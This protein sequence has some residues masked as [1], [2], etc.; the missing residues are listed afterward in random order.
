M[1]LLVTRAHQDPQAT[2]QV[3]GRPVVP[4]Y[5]D[6]LRRF[7]DDMGLHDAVTFTGALS[8]ADLVAAM[9]G[10]DVLV[11]PSR[12]EGF[13][14]PALEAM[15]MGLPVVANRAGALPEVVG[16]AGVL[17]DATDPYELAGAVARVRGDQDLR[18]TLVAA[19]RQRLE[20]LDLA[21]AGDRGADQILALGG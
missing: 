8:D 13:G 1:G 20:A 15:S 14:V 6:A 10:A 7:V 3:V 16:D 18:K 11:L 5:S 17:V 4:A 2:L 9:R 19:G 21:S 12:H